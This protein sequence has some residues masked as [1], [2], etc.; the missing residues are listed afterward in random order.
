M[1]TLAS[2]TAIV[3]RQLSL[4][5]RHGASIPVE[6]STAPLKGNEGKDFGVVGVFRDLT[7][8][9]ELESQLRR[10]DRLAAL[11]TLAAGLAHEIKNPL[12]SLLTFSRHLDRKFADQQFRERFRRVV[13]R[14]L[15]R[16]NAIVERLLELVRPTRLNFEAVRLPTVME[17][18]VEL[19]ANQIEAKHVTVTREYAHNLP[20]V[21]VDQ[22][23]LY[24]A[25][26]NLVG[27]ALDGLITGGQITLRARWTDRE[28]VLS[29]IDRSRSTRAIELEI[30]DTGPGIPVSDVDKIF[31]PFFTTKAGGTGLGLALVHKIVGE[32]DGIITVRSA[33]G[34]G[35]TFTIFLPL[36]PERH[37]E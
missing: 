24:R 21:M 31:N 25:L 11:G 32:H 37:T 34:E 14:E 36:A 17:R 9:R 3:G 28:E 30:Q 1:E 15:E 8:V 5:R 18:V 23:H 29:P 12:T 35:T 16:I 19:Y 20:P 22:E 7:R 6:L 33:P 13:P 2:R 10:S 27:N 26:V 4:K